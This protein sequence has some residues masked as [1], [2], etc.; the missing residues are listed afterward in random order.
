M[1]GIDLNGTDLLYLSFAVVYL[2]GL[3]RSKLR[4]RR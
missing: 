3:I 1:I 2:V 4:Y